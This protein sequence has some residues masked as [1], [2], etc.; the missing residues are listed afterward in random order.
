M[1]GDGVP[2][3]SGLVS[4]SD[5]QP[6]PSVVHR[7]VNRGL[8]SDTDGSPCLRALVSGREKG[9]HQLLESF[10]RSGRDF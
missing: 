5:D 10:E 8:G 9:V 2:P 4:V 1:V 3:P 7:R 6:G